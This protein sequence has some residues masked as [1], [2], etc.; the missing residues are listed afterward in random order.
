MAIRRREPRKDAGDGKTGQPAA[1]PPCSCC[2]GGLDASDPRFNITLPE[3]VATLDDAEYARQ[4]T[5]ANDAIVVAQDIGGFVRA[6]LPIGLDDG[7]TTTIGVWVGVAPEVFAHVV[8]V[9]RGERDYDEMQFDGRLANPLDPWGDRVYGKP[10]SAGV[11][12]PSRGRRRTPR[13]L[14]SPDPLV[15]RILTERWP[16]ADIL[17]GTRAWALPY[18]PQAPRATH[19]H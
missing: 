2:G 1:P 9:G 7:R 15:T 10:V 19:H 17:T 5:V 16:A 14:A 8:T 4:V 13:L 18:D 12:V 11:D 3:P 6:L